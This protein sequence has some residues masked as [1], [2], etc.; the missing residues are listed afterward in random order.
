MVI[1]MKK[2]LLLS[3]LLPSLAHAR[4]I[5]QYSLNYSSDK[6]EADT[7]VESS[8]TFHKIFLGASVNN[9]R[10][11]FFGWNINSWSTTFETGAIESEFSMTEM[12]PRFVY[13]FSEEYQ[14]YLTGEWNPYAKGERITD[15]ISGNSTSLGLGYRFKVNRYIGLGAGIHYHAL[16]VKESKVDSTE[17]D[18][19]EKRTTLMPMLELTILT[20]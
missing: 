20:H 12:G 11:F 9:K 6:E 13:F 2:W 15:E 4:F 14:W 19:S 7:E 8:K 1:I 3:L 16:S 17:N 10:T 18:V 5:L